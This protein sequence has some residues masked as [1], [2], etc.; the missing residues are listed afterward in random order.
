LNIEQNIITKTEFFGHMISYSNEFYTFIG[1]PQ[2][3]TGEKSLG[4]K[5]S[6]NNFIF[7]VV[8]VFNCFYNDKLDIFKPIIKKLSNLLKDYE[9]FFNLI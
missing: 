8:F 5:Y 6:R 9:V 2:N 1:I 3:I 4:E 7:N